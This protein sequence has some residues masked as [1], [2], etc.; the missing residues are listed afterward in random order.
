MKAG[1][2]NLLTGSNLL[3]PRKNL[4]WKNNVPPRPYWARPFLIENKVTRTFAE[5]INREEHSDRK[6][7]RDQV[8]GELAGL[9]ASSQRFWLS[10]YG[11]L[12]RTMSFGQLV[13]YA[14]AF[15]QLSR[16]MPK[17]LIFCRRMIVRKYIERFAIKPTPFVRKLRNQFV[18][19]SV[20]L[21]PAELLTE[22]SDK[23]IGLMRR[24]ADQSAAANRQRV[25]MLLRSLHMMTDQEICDQFQRES[26]YIDELHLLSELVRYYRIEIDDIFKVSAGEINR[27]WDSQGG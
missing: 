23:F 27:F 5:N 17:K 16:I 13:I 20:L 2:K 25:V 11:F 24:S 4:P 1:E 18:R 10:E 14:P 6:I 8:E 21:Y 15:V 26:E 22:A 19:S 7:L 3:K 9:L 12:E